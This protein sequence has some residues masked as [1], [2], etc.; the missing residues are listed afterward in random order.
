MPQR[1]PEAL[2]SAAADIQRRRR[3]LMCAPHA[4]DLTYEI[5]AWMHIG[6]RPDK[7]AALLQWQNLYNTLRAKMGLEVELVPQMEGAPDM[8]FT[9]NAG[10]VAGTKVLLSRFRHAERQVEVAPFRRWFEE[11]G[12]T[13][14]EPNPECA[15]EGEG[16]ALFAD[17]VLVAG[18][19][20]RSEI[21]SHQWLSEELG[22]QVLSVEL[23]DGRWYH[24]DT[25]F[26]WIG[27]RTVV[28]YPG[29]FDRYAQSVIRDRF[30]TIE[31]AEEE[32]LRFACNAVVVEGH[33][34]LADGCP[35][36]SAMLEQR[37]FTVHPLPLSEFIKAGGAAKC[38]TLFLG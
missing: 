8:V 30:D 21:C 35:K 16:D 26:F 13:C 7:A 5:N 19:L 25:A 31:V 15:F 33:V 32:A 22:V 34:A 1:S 9:A 38:L 24:L 37:G 11:S 29:A 17:G 27:G 36:L 10:I 20:K 14:I 12:Y 3:V 4:Y 6:N 23:T 18:Y 28:W 2:C